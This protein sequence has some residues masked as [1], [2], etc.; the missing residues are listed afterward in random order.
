MIRILKRDGSGELFDQGKLQGSMWRAM[1][2]TDGRPEDAA[3]LASAVAIY[4]RRKGTQVIS[5]AALFEMV[6]KV[7]R[8]VRLDAAAKVMEAHRAWRERERTNLR[9]VHECGKETLWDKSWLVQLACRSWNIQRP[10][11]RFLV[12]QLESRLLSKRCRSVSRE[13]L[14]NTINQMVTWYGLADAVPVHS[15]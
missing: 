1:R 8:R 5:S 7:F 4:L 9:V 15:R 13:H 12:G 10:T 3:E 2:G 11:G 14:V 6:L